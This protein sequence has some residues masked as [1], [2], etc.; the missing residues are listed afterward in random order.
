MARHALVV[1]KRSD[2]AIECGFVG[3]PH[4]DVIARST[5]SSFICIWPEGQT[6]HRD[7][8]DGADADQ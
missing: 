3:K 1:H 8:G 2:I 6:D 7:Q 5:F 4:C